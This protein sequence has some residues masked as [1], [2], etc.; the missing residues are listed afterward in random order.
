MRRRR[1]ALTA[2]IAAAVLI[3]L[4]V[5]ASPAPLAAGD[6]V[7]HEIHYEPESKTEATEFIELYN[8]GAGAVDLTGWFFSDGVQFTFPAATLL[9]PGG[10]LVVAEDP[11]ALAA[12][13]GID[14]P[15]G[16]FAGRLANDGGVD[17]QGA[18]QR[19]HDQDECRQRREQAGR[20]EGNGRLITQRA[21]I[22][23]AAQT[24]DGEPEEVALWMAVP[25]TGR[26]LL[27]GVHS[28]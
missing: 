18:E 28:E 25:T 15:L 24:H 3:G 19:Q 6:V 9:A 22:I 20:V 1:G 14:A 12:A 13:F 27:I 16:P 23:H 2:S 4:V 8:A 21:E 17:R 5:P 10:L 11:A 7:I 26:G